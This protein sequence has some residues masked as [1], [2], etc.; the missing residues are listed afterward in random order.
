MQAHKNRRHDRCRIATVRLEICQILRTAP[1]QQYSLGRCPLRGKSSMCMMC[2]KYRIILLIVIF[3]VKT[4]DNETQKA[5][6]QRSR[7]GN[8]QA[9]KNRR[10]DRC[11]IATARLEICQILRT[12]PLQQYSLGGCPLRGKSSMCMMC[13]KYRII[14]LIVIQNPWV[15][16]LT[17]FLLLGAT[18]YPAG[19][20][21]CAPQ[22]PKTASWQLHRF[23]IQRLTRKL[24][25]RNIAKCGEM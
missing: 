20:A 2:F 11:R 8:M 23:A 24:Q 6:A 21:Y 13:F 1:L 18:P 16:L 14:L 5:V 15:I 17:Y 19:G 7:I 3:S 22:T 12:A 25:Q 10:H 9:H 4:K